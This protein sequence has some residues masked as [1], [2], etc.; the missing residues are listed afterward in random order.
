[1]KKVSCKAVSGSGLVSLN[2]AS[3]TLGPSP[4][5]V[6]KRSAAHITALIL[7]REVGGGGS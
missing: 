1:M 5:P 4:D 7:T 2:P 6:C 3:S